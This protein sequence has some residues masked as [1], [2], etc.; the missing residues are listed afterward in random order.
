M[1][2]AVNQSQSQSQSPMTPRPF[3]PVSGLSL[4]GGIPRMDDNDP[5][6]CP[7]C[8]S[9]ITAERRTRRA[10]AHAKFKSDAAAAAKFNRHRYQYSNN[11]SY[12]PATNPANTLFSQQVQML[13]K[14]VEAAEAKQFELQSTVVAVDGADATVKQNDVL[15]KDVPIIVQ[16]LQ[17]LRIQ[18]IIDPALSVEEL[19][20]LC[21]ETS[22][23]EALAA[24]NPANS[25]EFA[26]L[27]QLRK[28]LETEV[29]RCRVKSS[30]GRRFDPSAKPTSHA[31]IASEHH[32]GHS[33]FL[34]NILT[35]DTMHRTFVSVTAL[36]VAVSADIGQ[37]L[38]SPTRCQDRIAVIRNSSG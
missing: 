8:P 19:T 28:D 17:S 2:L 16:V 36:A 34:G 33:A 10:A 21:T 23:S 27:Q 37:F 1:K 24:A 20:E 6:C 31:H 32:S 12:L 5:D 11:V 38:A 25:V 29:Y 9:P 3:D 26:R 15:S 14:A 4:S 7:D 22:R 35:S 30:F 18:L 13:C